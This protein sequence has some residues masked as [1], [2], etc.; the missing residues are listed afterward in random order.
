MEAIMRFKAFGT[1][2]IILMLMSS[3]APKE[4]MS[5]VIPME[6]FFKNPEVTGFSL[7]PDGSHLAFVKPWKTRLNVFVRKV[8]EDK[9]TRVSGA[10]ERDISGYFW[11]NNN[12]IG[13]IQD[14][15]GDENFNLYAVDIDG[16]EEKALTPFEKVRV[17]VVDELK[18]DEDHILIS[19]NRRDARVFDV[20]RI[21]INSGE[22][23]M[24]AQN[25]GN[26]TGW[27][28]DHDGNLRIAIT[29]DGV[30][31]S[32]LYRDTEKEDFQILITTN[33]KETLS[34]LFFSFD[35]KNLYVA[36]NL[37]RDKTAVYEYDI[38]KKETTKLLFEH[39]E[40]DVSGLLKSDKRKVVTGVA[41]V[42]DKRHYHF[43]D[44]ER[45][46]L[47]VNLE[48]R[49]PGYEVVVSDSSKDETKI[50]VRTYSDRSLGAYYYLDLNTDEFIKLAD[51]SPWLMED[52]LA[53][54]KPISY[55][56]RDGLTIH[57]YLTIPKGA[58][59]KDLPVIINPHGGP[60]ARNSWGFNPEVQFLAN[61]GYAVLQMNFRTS[62]GYGRKF[63][64]SGFKQIGLAIQDDITDGVKWLIAEGI[65]DP[66]RVGIYGASYGGYATLAGLV[67]TPDLYACGVDYVGV[68]NWFNILDNIP[69]YWEPMRE[70]L[71][72]MLGH[73]EKDKELLE[74]ISP[75]FHADKIKAPLFVA[76]GAN[77]PRVPK[78][79]SDTI[80]D[81]LKKREVEVEYMV[82]DNEG[83]GFRNEEN[84][85]DFYRAMEIFLGKHLGGRV[86]KKVN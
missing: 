69:P 38:A 41:Y 64:E 23:E 58:G 66:K 42:T 46:D 34:P 82:K 44:K 50:L 81:S 5:R 83:H 55:T 52:E 49:L 15:G 6:D 71:Y 2:L 43:F 70:M 53:E 28:T 37:G 18:N 31:T 72:E 10:T 22:L 1:L 7:S 75:L 62:T 11:A 67:Y 36:S 51:V 27:M 21:D 20:Y 14:K 33:F 65:A 56:S 45:E 54:M 47:Q 4:E 86:E 13:F 19:M 24:I 61:R 12:R 57:G 39:D 26:I 9:E 80:V 63:W 48:S 29:T 73:P 16:T 35:N 68:S 79:E 85:F 59:E 3:C 74:K 60:W 8:G 17:Q 77:D 78:S 76:Q 25:P 40:V 30:N 32:V 84:R